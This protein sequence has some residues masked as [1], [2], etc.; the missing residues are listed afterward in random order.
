MCFAT[1]SRRGAG[2]QAQRI[3]GNDVL[4][5]RAEVE[6]AASQIRIDGSGPFFFECMTYRYYGHHQGDDTH[7]YR[8]NQEEDA[9]RERDC[10]RI[11]RLQLLDGGSF[12]EEDLNAL[13]A[14][15][16]VALALKS[17]PAQGG[18]GT[19]MVR[20]RYDASQATAAQ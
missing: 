9:A 13:D 16:R 11:F 10:I 4:Q 8:T 12:S 20:N 7:R 19:I 2:L 5:I 15:N 18:I 1:C 3:E 17:I 6:K 14:S